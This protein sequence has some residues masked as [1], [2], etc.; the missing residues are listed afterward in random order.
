MD[1]VSDRHP[2]TQS[3]S[4]GPRRPKREVICPVIRSQPLHSELADVFLVSEAV[5][6]PLRK[7]SDL[8][9]R[10]NGRERWGDL[11]PPSSIQ[12]CLWSRV[13]YPPTSYKQVVTGRNLFMNCD[14]LLTPTPLSSDRTNKE[15]DM[16]SPGS[17]KF[18]PDES[19]KPMIL[20]S[21][22]VPNKCFFCIEEISRNWTDPYR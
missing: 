18:D 17:S 1:S 14:Y 6:R 3:W 9:G 19:C 22:Y 10:G 5:R 11:Y 4:C 2:L 16:V 12:Q 13:R 7:S 20:I 15:S 21:T 8:V